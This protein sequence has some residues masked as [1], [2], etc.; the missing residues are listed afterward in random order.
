MRDTT[1]FI[2]NFCQVGDEVEI[3]DRIYKISEVDILSNSA[4]AK[5]YF[6][7]GVGITFLFPRYFI[8]GKAVNKSRGG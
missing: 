1:P 2:T 3:E 8:E 5:R 4:T 7:N 6:E